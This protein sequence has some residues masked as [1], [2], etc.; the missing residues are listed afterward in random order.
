MQNFVQVGEQ[1]RFTAA[2]DLVSGQGFVLGSLFGVATQNVPSGG[3]G[4]ARIQGV[5]RLPKAAGAL[6]QW[7]KVY[8]DD[9]AKNV[10]GTATANRLIGAATRAQLAGDATVEVRLNGLAV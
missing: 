2:A 6:T 10:T 1:L 3:E 8:W 7:Q 4:V 5:V 9:T